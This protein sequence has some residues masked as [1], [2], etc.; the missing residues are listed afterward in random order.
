MF[1]PG[2]LVVCVDDGPGYGF[3]FG[4]ERGRVYTVAQIVRTNNGTGVH[5][6]EASSKPFDAFRPTRFRPVSKCSTDL[7]RS[8]LT[9]L[10]SYAEVASSSRPRLPAA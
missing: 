10:P 6:E 5:V 2:D 8:M 9:D 3:H 4:L 1:R 7:L